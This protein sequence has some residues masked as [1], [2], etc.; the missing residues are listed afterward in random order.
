VANPGERGLPAGAT[1]QFSVHG[2]DGDTLLRYDNAPYHLD[3]HLLAEYDII[4]FE[5]NGR[6]KQP[7]VPYVTVRIEVAFGLPRREGS[8]LAASAHY[9]HLAGES[10][11]R[12]AASYNHSGVGRCS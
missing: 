12:T 4:H 7:H 5:E 2:P 3:V 9:S 10:F 1:V 6:A 11:L 8:D